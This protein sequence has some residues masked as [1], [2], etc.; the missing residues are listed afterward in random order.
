ME[1]LAVASRSPS[2][3]TTSDVARADPSS[4]SADTKLRSSPRG[5]TRRSVTDTESV[6]EAMPVIAAGPVGGAA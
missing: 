5:C 2:V 1:K 3:N 4:V 6:C